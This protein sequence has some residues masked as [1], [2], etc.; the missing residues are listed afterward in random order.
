MYTEILYEG[1]CTKRCT[2]G[3]ATYQKRGDSWRAIIR[4]AG[5]PTVTATFDTKA[6]AQKWVTETESKM[7]AG[8]Y[9]DPRPHNDLTLKVAFDRYLEE[10]TARKK[11]TS[12]ERSRIAR[13]QR[14]I[15]K[16]R[17][18]LQIG[19]H[20]LAKF[21]NER[22]AEGASQNSVRLDL[23][24]IS[25][26][27]T[28]AIKEWGFKD[29]QNPVLQ[30]TLPSPG[31]GRDRRLHPGEEERLLAVASEFH[32]ELH[33]II[34]VALETAMRRAEI[35]K[36]NSRLIRDGIAVIRDTK[37]GEDRRVPLSSRALAAIER[38]TP[39]DDGRI[40]KIHIGDISRRFQAAAKKVG[41]EDLH[42]HDL[43]HEATSRLF[44]KGFSSMEVATITG[45]KTLQMLKRYTHLRVQD[46]RARLG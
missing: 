46:L 21:R 17:P 45:H 23:A 5:Q 38:H 28:I 9:V 31:K 4:K 36:L 14:S 7:D 37:N 18:L 16:D 22:L 24:V 42:F 44:E 6:A 34:I 1:Y 33:D 26:L 43:R 27:Y 11:N 10:V 35:S 13:W 2:K 19:S 29:L 8:R 30:L 41:A 3:M 12:G 32:G 20:D 25:H 39:S 40:F 15:I